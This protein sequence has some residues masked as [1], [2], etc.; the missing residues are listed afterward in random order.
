MATSTQTVSAPFF[1]HFIFG[2]KKNL[3]AANFVLTGAR[4]FGWIGK[5][6]KQ[7]KTK[8]KKRKNKSQTACTLS[9]SSA[10]VCVDHSTSTLNP[11]L[12][13]MSLVI[14]FI[15]ACFACCIASLTSPFLLDFFF[16]DRFFFIFFF[17][18][19]GILFASLTR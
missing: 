1:G 8:N 12:F 9:G 15:C 19:D 17:F 14:S 6:S 18:L 16:F 13:G 5:K 3:N 4:T 11:Y 10:L 2:G 7:K